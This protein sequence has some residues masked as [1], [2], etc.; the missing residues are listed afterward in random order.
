MTYIVREMVEQVQR[1]QAR[2]VHAQ[3]HGNGEEHLALP[4]LDRDLRD[5]RDISS[6]LDDFQLLLRLLADLAQ[7]L[8]DLLLLVGPPLRPST[9][10]P[11]PQR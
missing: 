10:H 1:H 4:A 9:L 5:Q 2:Q 3:Q 7:L 6:L 11:Q 8:L